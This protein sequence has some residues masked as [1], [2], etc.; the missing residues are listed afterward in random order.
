MVTEEQILNAK[1]LIIDEKQ[2][3]VSLL[4][5]ILQRAGYRNI[6]FTHNP[7]RAID[8]Y[9]QI[10]PD[11]VFLDIDMPHLNGFEIMGQLKAIEGS[12]YLPVAII[13]DTPDQAI[14]HKA[15]ESGAK[16]FLNK[17]YNRVEVLVRIHNLIEVRM[18]HTE[19]RHQNKILEDKVKVRTQELYETQLDVIQRL[20]RAV[21]YRDSET[22]LHVIR[23]SNY[24]ACLSAEYGLNMEQCELIL[25]AAPLHDIGKIG[26]PDAILRK[27][28]KLT[29]QEWEIMKTHTTIGAELL[30]GSN[31]RFL[32][33]AKTIALTH[34]E[35][36]D[37]S[38]YPYGLK[39]D[40]IPI[41]GQICGL[42]DVFDALT[43]KR[44]YKEA[45]TMDETLKAI[46]KFSDIQFNPKLVECF[47]RVL[48]KIKHINQ[49]YIDP[50][51][52][53][54]EGFER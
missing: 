28:G 51:E 2:G 48:P 40:E 50:V 41:V 20:A 29:P 7:V 23:M 35:R 37:G 19:V 42:S 31:S 1:I 6:T 8:L 38:G 13:S 26:I 22:G 5:E 27:P 11:L 16:D 21:E 30:S 39:G 14:R 32:I 43:T 17:P 25:T 45:W 4:M 54:D 33:M 9:S 47:F 36:W 49:K 10:K 24:A 18:L 53:R 3:A 15:L 46:Q 44:P 34:H 52:A 12:S